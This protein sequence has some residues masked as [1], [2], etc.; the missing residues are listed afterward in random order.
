V[1][2]GRPSEE[3]FE[4]MIKKGK[5]I[6]HPVS[7][8]NFRNAKKIY[9]KDLGMIKGKTVREKTNHIKIEV[10]EGPEEKHLVILS[11]DVMHLMGI[12]Y[13]VTV[14]R[15]FFFITATALLDRK[16][17]TLLNA[18]KYAINVYKSKGHKIEEMEFSQFNNDIHIILADNEFK[19]L[20]KEIEENGIKVN[21]TA[22][23]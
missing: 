7:V 19:M 14:T 20:R 5:I 8:T 16:K 17:K 10:R 4:L 6:N 18:L 11:V 21:I 12:S 23:D 9:G 15:D 22:I 2:L 3:S 1:I 13:L